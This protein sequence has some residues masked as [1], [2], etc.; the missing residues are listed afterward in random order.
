MVHSLPG[1]VSFSQGA[2]LSVPYGTAYRG[3]HHKAHARPGET[4]LV[5]GASGGVGVAAVRLAVAPGMTVIGTP[6]TERGGPPLPGGGA[7]QA[8]APPAP[9]Y[10]TK[11]MELTGNP[12]AAASPA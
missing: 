9:P 7:H 2:A 4:L 3:L 8:L 10:L 11:V 5:H 12:G 1:N 6:G